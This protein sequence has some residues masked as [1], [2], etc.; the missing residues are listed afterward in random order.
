MRQIN[1]RRERTA[2]KQKRRMLA[3][4][5]TRLQ[6]AV[7][8]P[9][10]AVVAENPACAV[11]SKTSKSRGA[12]FRAIS[13]GRRHEAALGC[14]FW[15]TVMRRIQ[16]VHVTEYEYPQPVTLLGHR[17]LVRPREGHDLRIESSR[18]DVTPGYD[19]RWTR[20]VYGNISA[21]LDFLE[22]S[23]HLKITSEVIVQLHTELTMTFPLAVTATQF[24][25]RYD[26][27]E[28]QDLSPYTASIYPAEEARLMSWLG[29]T[30]LPGQTWETT[31]WL[32]TINARIANEISYEVREAP[33]VQPPSTTLERGRGSC[34]DVATLFIEICRCSGLAARF[35]SGYLL[36]SATVHDTRSTHAWSEVYLPGGGWLGFDSTSGL[37]VGSDHVA[38][39]VHRHPEAVAPISGSFVGPADLA[40]RMRVSVDTAVL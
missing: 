31:Q 8:D 34:R 7:G 12:R 24:P 17:L 30:W 6:A 23:K 40:P 13:P 32:N 14:Q 36:S 3:K 37:L 21:S 27:S 38:V 15:N 9:F 20:D 18:L 26:T 28:Q 5:L 33:G 29:Q 39:A 2:Q 16:I 1:S 25:F 10:I 19:I 22:R 11:Q 4:F 35:V